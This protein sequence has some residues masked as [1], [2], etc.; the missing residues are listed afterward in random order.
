MILDT[1]G[2]RHAFGTVLGVGRVVVGVPFVR[3]LAQHMLHVAWETAV[4]A[5]CTNA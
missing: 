5:A 2:N 4:Q 3:H 1:G